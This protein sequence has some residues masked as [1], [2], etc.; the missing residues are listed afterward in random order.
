[1]KLLLTIII[2][3]FHLCF[4]SCWS[5][6]IQIIEDFKSSAINQPGQEYPQVNSQSRVR[7][8]IYAPQANKVQLDLGGV[9]YDKRR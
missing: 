9:K 7:A 2:I 3:I 4:Q 8:R 6:E 1:M 5:Q